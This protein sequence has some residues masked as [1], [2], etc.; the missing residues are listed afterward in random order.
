MSLFA[1]A[2]YYAPQYPYPPPV[3]TAPKLYVAGSSLGSRT[4]RSPVQQPTLVSPNFYSGQAI[5]YANPSPSPVTQHPPYD[6]RDLARTHPQEYSTEPT[7]TS[8]P[9][10][11]EMSQRTHQPQQ[12]MHSVPYGQYSQGDMSSYLHYPLPGTA[13]QQY[14]NYEVPAIGPLSPVMPTT[15]GALSSPQTPLDYS[16]PPT[17]YRH[18]PFGMPPNYAAPTYNPNNQRYGNPDAAYEVVNQPVGASASQQQYPRMPLGPPQPALPVM[19]TELARGHF[20]Q[21]KLRDAAGA[22]D[23]NS[24][25]PLSASERRRQSTGAQKMPRPPSHSPWALWVG[26]VPSDSTHTE[27]WRFF[28][29]RPPPGPPIPG[30]LEAKEALEAEALSGTETISNPDYDSCGIESIHLI[31]RSNCCFVNMSSKRHLEHAIKVCNGQSLRPS[32]PRCK[33][34][35]C[36]VRKK[37][38]DNKTGVGA[39]RGKGMHQAWVAAEQDAQKKDSIASVGDSGAFL[40]SNKVDNL[41]RNDMQMGYKRSATASTS[42]TTSS[43]LARHFPQRYFILKVIF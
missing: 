1:S 38:D 31:S 20:A 30:S 18:M 21:A 28:S 16:A 35:V 32:D 36:R 34:L 25:L 43:F 15:F 2:Q 4:P 29:T 7:S 5:Y 11:S 40:L 3:E 13:P 9:F 33:T 12:F 23:P 17:P 24:R 14:A 39:Q 22:Y 37:E 19:P 27:L 26:N 6:Q 42:S 8:R 41:S 10:T